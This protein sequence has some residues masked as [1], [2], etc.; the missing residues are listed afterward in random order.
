MHFLSHE[1]YAY[2]M[3][4][5]ISGVFLILYIANERSVQVLVIILRILR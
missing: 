1:N 2:L 3:L 5:L 4:D